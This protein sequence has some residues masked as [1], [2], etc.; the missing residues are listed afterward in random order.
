M[1]EQQPSTPQQAPPQGSQSLLMDVQPPAVSHSSTPQA[2]SPT[3]TS[4]PASTPEQATAS[5]E[6]ETARASESEQTG[7]NFAVLEAVSSDEPNKST[8]P[9][10]EAKAAATS[11]RFRPVVAVAI[12]VA[13]VLCGVAVYAYIQSNQQSTSSETHQISGTSQPTPE[14]AAVQDIEASQRV[15]D[16]AIN[17]NIDSDFPEPELT[18]EAL[19]L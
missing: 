6:I 18:D 19:G 12:I 5:T 1:N 3:P 11:S 8:Q 16:E 10:L 14:N 15:V 4:K 9:L 2:T 7:S 13:L 17:T